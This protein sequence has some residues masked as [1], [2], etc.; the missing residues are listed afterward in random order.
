MSIKG[1]ATSTSSGMG[2]AGL[3]AN[4]KKLANKEVYVGIPAEK[5]SRPGEPINNAELLYIQ[6]KGSELQ[7]IPARP[8]LEPSIDKNKVA[9]SKNLTKA[10]SE[11]MAGNFDSAMQELEKAGIVASQG[12]KMYITDP[13]Y[14]GTIP[15]A[16]ATIAKKGSDVPLIDTGAMRNAIT[17]VVGDKK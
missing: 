8:V 10:L 17:Y 6:S 15:D 5:S 2:M 7:H 4:I 16:P 14:K 11:G 9:I 12:A 1:T 13:G 3:A